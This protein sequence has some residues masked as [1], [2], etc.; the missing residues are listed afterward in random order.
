MKSIRTSLQL[1]LLALTLALPQVSFGQ[2][3]ASTEGTYVRSG[4]PTT[5]N[6]SEDRALIG[7]HET[8]TLRAM[9]GVY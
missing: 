1:S 6:L 3:L 8:S 7:F 5:N 9:R 4:A 2:V